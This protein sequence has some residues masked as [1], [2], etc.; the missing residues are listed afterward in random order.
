[1]KKSLSI[2]SM[3]LLTAALIIPSGRGYVDDDRPR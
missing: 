2:I 1:M 3:S